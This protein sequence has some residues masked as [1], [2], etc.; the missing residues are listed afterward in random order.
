[1]SLFPHAHNRGYRLSFVTKQCEEIYNTRRKEA[2]AILPK[3]RR[4]ALDLSSTRLSSPLPRY[5]NLFPLAKNCRSA[6]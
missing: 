5:S 2:V 1:M 4:N 6:S 3:N